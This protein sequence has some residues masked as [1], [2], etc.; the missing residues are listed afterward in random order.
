MKQGVDPVIKWS[1]SKRLVAPQLARLFKRAKLFVDPFVGG[2]AVLPYATANRIIVGDIVAELVSLWKCIQ[3]DPNRV[4][5][6]YTRRW[7]RLQKEGHT[8]YYAIRDDFNETRNPYD[9]LFLSRTC[10]NGLIR[11][12]AEGNFNNSLHH[13]RP[14]IAPERLRKVILEWHK[15]LADV[16]FH[17]QDYRET[18]SAVSKGDMV[19]LDPPYAGTKGRYRAGDFSTKEFFELL[20]S[21]NRKG[22]HWVLTFDGM[23]GDRKY[24][25][26]LNSALYKHHLGISTGNSTFNKVI[27]KEMK[28]VVESV[29]LNFD[30]SLEALRHFIH[31]GGEPSNLG[32]TQEVHQHSL[33]SL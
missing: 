10:V 25:T 13:T 16:E 26:G 30:P 2:G 6:E 21:L 17:H 33:F 5:D 32:L 15:Y 27:D 31:F 9:F 3:S 28:A 7:T 23:A 1:G 12:N 8:A 20:E 22:V 29:F 24:E 19:F 18:L 11:F 14:G 4:A